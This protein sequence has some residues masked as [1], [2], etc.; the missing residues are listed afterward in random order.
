MW[1]ISIITCYIYRSLCT[2]AKRMIL[3][4]VE[5]KPKIENSLI[6]YAD[7]GSLEHQ[8]LEGQK[9]QLR[10]GYALRNVRQA[11]LRCHCWS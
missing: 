3:Y 9:A 1:V 8:N 6:E 10:Q 11:Y 7:A 4:S 5:A 2:L